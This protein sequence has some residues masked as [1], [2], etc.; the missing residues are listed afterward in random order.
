MAVVVDRGA[1]AVGA[2][3]GLHHLARQPAAQTI[4][5]YRARHQ[6]GR[7]PEIAA[8]G[9]R[10][11]S[12]AGE[13]QLQPDGAGPQATGGRPRRD[14]RRHLARPAHAAHAPAPGNRDEPDRRP[15]PR[16]DGGRHRTDG[17]HHRPVP[18]L[19]A[20]HRRDAG[21]R[22]PD[23]TGAR[24]RTG[25]F[26][27]RRHRPHAQ[28]GARGHRPLQPDGNAAH[29]RQP[30]RERTPLWQDAR[31]RPRRDHGQHRAA[32]QRGG[33]VRGRPRRRRA[34]RPVSAVDAAVLPAGIR[35][36]RSQG[37]GARHVDREPDTAA[38]RRSAH[39]GEPHATRD[40]ADRQRLLRTRLIRII[41]R[42]HAAGHERCSSW[43]SRRVATVGRQAVPMAA[44]ETIM[45]NGSIAAHS[46]RIAAA[47]LRPCLVRPPASLPEDR[48]AP[49]C[50][51][52]LHCPHIV[53]R[54]A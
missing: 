19:C 21:N 1:G 17:R 52:R 42:V 36:Q 43:L 54:S 10:H 31:H 53:R 50:K 39:A 20:P 15:D 45:I 44:V 12:G 33:A 8:R 41:R 30:G 23:R 40:R 32:G 24:Y 6:R 9:R 18:G 14:A 25:L 46:P 38:Q 47:G 5:R 48:R 11:G 3:R 49:A 51:A 34:G 28:A 29:P 13:S 16:A 22:R 35:A 7:R 2:G 27:P 37:G 4:G 26:H